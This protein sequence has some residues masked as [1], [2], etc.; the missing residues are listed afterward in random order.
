MAMGRTE[1]REEG[2]EA[3]YRRFASFGERRIGI[4]TTPPSTTAP[5]FAPRSAPPRLDT[6]PRK[7]FRR[8]RRRGGRF[9]R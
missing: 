6:C 3:D 7:I 5:T 2:A 8:M 9:Y 1:P 4:S